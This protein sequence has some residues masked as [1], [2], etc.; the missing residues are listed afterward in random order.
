MMSEA[1]SQPVVL[2]GDLE[3]ARERLMHCCASTRWVEAMLAHRPFRD[4][5]H[6]YDCAAVC[7]R[8]LARADWLEAFSQ[9]PR[10]GDLQRARLRDDAERAWAEVEQSG[11]TRAAESVRLALSE[12]NHEYEKR[13]G[14]AFI[15][16]ATGKSGEEMLGILRKRLSNPP[17]AELAIAAAEQ[18]KITRI[19]LE[20]LL[21][22]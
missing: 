1:L 6:V 14:Y 7:W 11:A 8:G 20:K 5:K 16:C 19:R 15:V 12:G 10:I 3:K 9:H 21:S 18:E 13:F 22:Q 4:L 2:N 17:E